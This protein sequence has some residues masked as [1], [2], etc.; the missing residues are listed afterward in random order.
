[1]NGTNN[2]T[3]LFDLSKSTSLEAKLSRKFLQSLIE[4]GNF[5]EARRIKRDT[6][7]V[8][9]R[10]WNLL[11]DL[12]DAIR[13]IVDIVGLGDNISGSNVDYVNG[14]PF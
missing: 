3:K 7:V 11:D 8:Q 14:T 9:R 6:N 13:R 10:Q 12:V 2:G 5:E 1:M 4:K